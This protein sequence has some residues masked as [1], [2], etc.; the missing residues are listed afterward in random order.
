MQTLKMRCRSVACL[1]GLLLLML[2]FAYGQAGYEAQLRGTVTDP[3]GALVPGA[4]VTLINSATG[5]RAAAKTNA[6]GVYTFNALRPGTYSLRVEH[7]GFAPHESE[8][9]V[10][11]VS[12]QAVLDEIQ[13]IFRP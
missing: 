5:I 9:L 7:A 6:S 3:G 2:T 10:L 11:A 4:A 8:G 1:A 13:V 12:Q